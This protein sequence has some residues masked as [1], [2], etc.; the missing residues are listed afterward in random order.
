VE[1]QQPPHRSHD[2]GTLKRPAPSMP[3]WHPPPPTTPSPPPSY[4]GPTTKSN[5]YAGPCVKC[6]Q[7]VPALTGE[8]TYD[9]TSDKWH[10][11]CQSGQC[12]P[13]QSKP[14]SRPS[15]SSTTRTRAKRKPLDPSVLLD[16]IVQQALDDISF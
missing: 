12:Q 14:Q 9:A 4:S 8:I 5:K 7:H 16:N 1:L 11:H 2:G 10:L 3:D 13:K 15:A 6:G